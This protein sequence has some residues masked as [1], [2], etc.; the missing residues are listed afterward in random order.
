MTAPTWN[1]L[2]ADGRMVCDAAGRKV[3]V[4]PNAS[5]HIVVVSEEAGRRVYAE[6]MPDEADLFCAL[7]ARAA[8]EGFDLQNYLESQYLTYRAIETAKGAD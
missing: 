1:E 3:A 5:G 2:R 6:V 8:K 7:V 4:Y